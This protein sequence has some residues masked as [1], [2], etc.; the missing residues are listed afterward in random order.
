MERGFTRGCGFGTLQSDEIE[1]R[2]GHSIDFILHVSKA[3]AELHQ[4][5]QSMLGWH[6]YFST[7]STW[8]RTGKIAART[9]EL[10]STLNIISRT[11][12]SSTA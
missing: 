1:K 7:N 9:S 4:L 6:R 3:G 8:E 5:D 10:L 12:F 11:F 2:R